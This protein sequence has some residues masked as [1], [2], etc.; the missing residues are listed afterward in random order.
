MTYLIGLD[1]G[2]S[3]AKALLVDE[4]GAVRAS[5][6]V[7]YDYQTP[8]PLWAEQDPRQWWQ[9]SAAAIRGLLHKESVATEEIAAIGLT[10]QMVGL[11]ALDAAGEPVR[12]CIMWNDQRS[13]A[14]CEA[15][16][17]MLGFER[18]MALT[19]N[20]VLPG[21]VAPKVLW[22]REHEPDAFQRIAHILLPKD[23]VRFR[24]TG[25]YA[26]EVSDASGTS[27]FD[28]VHRR[29]SQEMLDILKIPANWLPRC[30][31]SPEVTGTLTS[32]AAEATGLPAGIP[33]V[34]GA[35]DQPAQAVGSGIVEPGVV[36]VTTGTSGVVFTATPGPSV[37]PQGLLH[38]FCHAMPDAWYLMGVML[39]AGGSLRWYRD[40]LAQAEKSVAWL[41][42]R[43]PYELLTAEAEQAPVGSEGLLFL[44]YLSG[45]RTPHVDPYARGAWLGLT[46]RHD[47]RH[48][49]R[50]VLEGVAFGLR[51]SLELVHGLGAPVQQIRA[52]GGG[53]RSTLWRQIQ[54]DVFGTELVTVN[55]T[56][57]AAYGAAILAAV[58]VGIF[59]SVA[60]ACRALFRVETHTQPVPTHVARYNELYALYRQA[61]PVLKPLNDGLSR[62]AVTS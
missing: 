38:A 57:G 11:V 14:Q 30:Y 49:V 31:E 39:S 54:A 53:A 1:V 48:L 24:L 42:G 12:P 16:T 5:V 23:Y 13:G 9:A 46:T 15:I 58:G 3:G 56:E 62:L 28:V 44:P 41:A 36:S 60:C 61:Y 59:P 51:D 34:G 20:P 8:Q 52:S 19:S 50:A 35:G 7:E 43:D 45:E 10:G 32:L 6:T 55:E 40:V 29:W 22:V 27:L 18:L 26:T 37:H 25:E 2:T 21:F 47:R 33:V 4:S 17:S